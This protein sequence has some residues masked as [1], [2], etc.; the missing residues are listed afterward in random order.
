ML[1]LSA[2]YYNRWLSKLVDPD[3]FRKLLER[4]IGFLRRLGPIS[5]TCKIDCSILEK[6][7]RHLFGVPQDEKYLYRNEGVEG[8]FTAEPMSV[9]NSFGAST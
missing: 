3:R 8:S 4:T 2:T 9:N 1:V 6:I 5:P 7:H